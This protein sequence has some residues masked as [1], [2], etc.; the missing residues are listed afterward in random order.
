MLSQS[1]KSATLVKSV[2]PGGK[3]ITTLGGGCGKQ[4]NSKQLNSK[5]LG[6]KQSQHAYS[7]SDYE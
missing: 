4:L 1:V 5:Q 3:V 2:A 7:D 6:D